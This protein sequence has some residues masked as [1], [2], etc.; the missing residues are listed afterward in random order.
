MAALPLRRI[1]AS[2]SLCCLVPVIT[3]F[4]LIYYY[5]DHL[6][7]QPTYTPSGTA[8]ISSYLLELKQFR[9]SPI[10]TDGCSQ[11]RCS[12]L[13]YIQL[14]ASAIKGYCQCTKLIAPHFEGEKKPNLYQPYRDAGPAPYP[15]FQHSTRGFRLMATHAQR[16]LRSSPYP[17]S[18]LFAV[19]IIPLI[20][21]PVFS[22]G[23]QI[24]AG[25]HG[26]HTLSHLAA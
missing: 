12:S 15:L 22:S 10:G 9:H 16:L 21:D 6:V 17:G 13:P 5:I 23:C 20:E 8:P 18:T 4:W 2:S 19:V 11:G 7:K 3:E 25:C 26:K 1:K 14:S 24:D